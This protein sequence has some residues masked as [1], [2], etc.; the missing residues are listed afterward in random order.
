MKYSH[1]I[2]FFVGSKTYYQEVFLTKKEIPTV[3]E[4]NTFTK[5]IAKRWGGNWIAINKITVSL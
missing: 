4:W 3:E 2:T 1:L 5:E